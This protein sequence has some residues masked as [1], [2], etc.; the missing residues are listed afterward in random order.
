MVLNDMSPSQSAY[1]LYYLLR[2]CVLAEGCEDIARRAYMIRA[3]ASAVVLHIDGP[4]TIYHFLMNSMFMT[5][6]EGEPIVTKAMIERDAINEK[7][8]SYTGPCQYVRGKCTQN[9]CPCEHCKCRMSG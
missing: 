5:N 3:I 1:L 9:P 4:F 6:D 7:K 8:T 2:R